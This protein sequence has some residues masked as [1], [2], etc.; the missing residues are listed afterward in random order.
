MQGRRV[1]YPWWVDHYNPVVFLAE[2]GKQREQQTQLATTCRII[3][4]LCHRTHGPAI[5]WQGIIQGQVAA[6]ECLHLV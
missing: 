1:G 5:A 2:T 3:N 4:Q 6:A